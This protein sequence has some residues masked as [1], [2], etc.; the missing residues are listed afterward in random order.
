[1]NVYTQQLN[2]EYLM[3]FVPLQKKFIH[4]EFSDFIFVS[5]RILVTNIK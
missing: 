1:M 3:L 4:L 5:V 2:I